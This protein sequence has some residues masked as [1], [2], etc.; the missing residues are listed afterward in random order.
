[1]YARSYLNPESALVYGVSIYDILCACNVERVV[2]VG[3]LVG[4]L[5]LPVVRAETNE[6]QSRSAHKRTASKGS[7]KWQLVARHVLA[8]CW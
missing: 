8:G 1:M 7:C 3:V 6:K 5:D 4:K 2:W